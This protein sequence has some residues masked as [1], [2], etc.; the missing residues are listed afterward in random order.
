MSKNFTR[1]DFLK[2]SAVAMG[3]AT[4]TMLTGCSNATSNEDSNAVTFDENVD[5]LIIGGGIGG[6]SSAIEAVDNGC[7][8]VLIIEKQGAVGGCAMMSGGIIGGYGTELCKKHGVDI[9][10][11]SLIEEQMREKKYILDPALTRLTM[12]KTKDT[13]NWLTNVIGVPFEDG[14]FTKDGYGTHQTIHLVAGEGKGMREPFN[15]ALAAR[16]EIEV[17]LKTSASKLITDAEGAVIGAIITDSEGVTK[18]IGAKAVLVATGGFN[19]NRDLF[20]TTHSANRVFQTSLVAAS[21]GDGLVMTTEIGAGTNS[22]DQLQVYL[23]EYNNPASQHPY[24]Y[25]IF[26][27]K[28][29]KRFMDEKRTAQTYN[30]EIKDDVIALYGRTGVDYFYSIADEASLSLMGIADAS[31][32]HAGT[33]YADTLEELADKIGVNKENFLAEVA[34]WN[35]CVAK[36]SDEFGRSSFWFPISTGPFYALQTTW[37][38]SVCHGGITK[39]ENAQVTRFDGSVIPNLYAC[40]EVC[41]VTNSNGYTISNAITFGRIAAQHVMKNMN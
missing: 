14:V 36:Q 28:D 33:V 21:T 39:N 24:M 31:K 41:V 13:L 22:L 11:E 20:A 10:L 8:N 26:V 35:E 19:A 37:F 6:L 2:G 34:K 3:L 30:Q 23:R 18:K 40:G 4:A 5:Y 17:R 38:S 16:P 1:R 7:K 15:Q 32:D 27:G 29:G 25:T 9:D 12:E